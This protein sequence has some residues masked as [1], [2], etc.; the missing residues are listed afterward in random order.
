M[1]MLAVF[2]LDNCTKFLFYGVIT[3]GFPQTLEIMK[4]LEKALKKVPCM[5][6]SWNLKKPE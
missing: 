3:A 1:T 4:N 6:K 5:E 2:Y